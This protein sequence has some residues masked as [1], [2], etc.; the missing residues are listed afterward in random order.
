MVGEFRILLYP[1]R[2]KDSKTIGFGG[3]L[4]SLSFAGE[5]KGATVGMTHDVKCNGSRR[6]DDHTPPRPLA[7]FLPILKIYTGKTVLDL[8]YCVL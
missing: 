5:R 3:V 1:V 7:D 4:S 6:W 2:E 8:L